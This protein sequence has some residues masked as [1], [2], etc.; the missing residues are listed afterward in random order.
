[1]PP[2][3]QT[4][5]LAL[6]AALRELVA[7]STIPAMWV[8]KETTVIAASLAD[9]L[10]GSLKLDFVFVRLRDPE[11][12]AA[13]QLTRGHGW[14]AFPEWL[15]T[16]FGNGGFSSK[17][18]VPDVGD[19]E[20]RRGVA[21]PVGVNGEGGVVA[22]ASGRTD[23]PSEIDHLLLS[24]AANRAA[25]AFQSAYLSSQLDA[26]VAELSRARSEL[27]MKVLERTSDLR[28]SEAYLADAQQLSHTGSFG[29]DAASGEIYWSSETFR[30]CEVE[31][32]AKVTLDL[33]LQRTH[34]EDRKAVRQLI[35]RV[36]EQ[37]IAFDFEH[38]L[39]MPGGSVKYVHVVGRP[40]ENESGLLQF[41][42]AVTDVSERKR[43]EEKFRGL[44]ESAPDAMVVMNRQGRIVLVNA[45]V[46][47]LFGYQR[48]ELLGQ[49]IEI[50]V[51]ERFRGQ[52]PG[53]RL[54]FFTQP[55]V[56]PMGLGLELYARRQ[57]GTE[58]PVEISLS[59]LETEEGTL[60]SGAVR[61]I[62][63]RKQAEQER[64]RLR[65]T[66]ADL[67]YMS[68]VITVGELGASL[69]HE[70]KQPIAATVL[71]AKTCV[72]WLNR[73]PPDVRE[74]CES[75]ARTV[76]DALHAAEIIDRIRSL[77]RRGSP[78]RELVDVNEIV[79]EMISLL[80]DTANRCSIAIRA[81]LA[82]SLDKVMADRI[83]LQ[84]VL[85]NLM[86]NGIEAMRDTGG[87]LTVTSKRTEV[88][89]LV[90]SVGDSGVG[91]PQ[92][93]P[94]RIFEAF[95]TTKAQGTGMGLSI[96]RT[97]VESHGGRLWASANPQGGATFHFTLPAMATPPS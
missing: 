47:K 14:E 73:D 1:M 81:D 51:P 96:S 55:R 84:Q 88:G 72:R 32:T 76:K 49:E 62:T 77:Y 80:H 85:L 59:P 52:H 39:I 86:L 41:V 18:I 87:K 43:A 37:K 15:A 35:E 9:V 69:A 63:D 54:T 20:P 56:R 11:G 74:A 53:H 6:R 13:I 33:M 26:K 16:H 8:G 21:I 82:E 28:R 17:A 31:P 95:F 12:R 36:S 19:A 83:Q 7:L 24:V 45:Q 3:S 78:R 58:F 68:R 46:E 60:V 48:D 66:Q 23:F 27:E 2:E 70:V 34:P 29:W 65:R 75:A 25:T 38:R 10:I 64:E 4:E 40:S 91:L 67:A 22:A 97:I 30:I 92:E 71:N 90:I 93:Q 57:D 79:R 61:D 42:G 50:L 89:Q 94:D 5:T 44:L